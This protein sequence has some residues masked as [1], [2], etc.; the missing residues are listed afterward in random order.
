MLIR[1]QLSDNYPRGLEFNLAGAVAYI[2]LTGNQPPEI[3]ALSHPGLHDFEPGDITP[4]AL[5][6]P[7]RA[8]LNAIDQLRAMYSRTGAIAMVD[9]VALAPVVPGEVI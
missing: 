7:M 1:I 3:E 6:S 4:L 8:E 9:I 2:V 5:M